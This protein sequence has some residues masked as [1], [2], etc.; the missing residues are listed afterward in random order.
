LLATSCRQAT[1]VLLAV[2]FMAGAATA[3]H[4]QSAVYHLHS[5]ASTTGSFKQ[6]KAAGPDVAQ[7]TLQTAAL[8]GAAVGEKQIAQFDTATGV[9]GTAGRIPS[10]AMVSAVVWMRKTANF[11][12]MFPRIKVRLNSSAG[13]SL[14]TATGTTALTTT[15]T[16][17]SISCTTTANVTVAASDRLYVWAGVNLTVASSGGAFRGELGLEGTLNGAADSRVDV[18]TALPAP[19]ITSPNPTAG[20]VGTVVTIS[21]NNFR[22]QQLNGV[23]RFFNNRTAT[24]TSWSNTSIVATV[25]ASAVNGNVTVTVAGVASAGTWFG[26]GTVPVITQVSPTAGLPGSAVT[27]T[28]S[29]FGATKGSSAVRF[30]GVTAATTSWSATSIGATVPAAATSGNVVVTV[31]NIPSAGTPFTVPTLTSITVLPQSL[32]VPIGGAQQLTALGHYSDSIDRNISSAVSWSSTDVDVVSVSPTGLV[33]TLAAAGSATI[34][35]SLGASSNVAE[36]TAAP[37]RFK[38]VGSLQTPRLYHAA[39]LL[40]GGKVLVTGGQDGYSNV[41]ATAEVYDSATGRFTPTGNM[42]KKRHHHTATTL[43]DGRVLIVGGTTYF[44]DEDH[45]TAEI[46]DPA[47]G[48]FAFTGSMSVPRLFHTAALL[49]DGRVLIEQGALGFPYVPSAEVYNP[50]TGT[51]SVTTPPAT[52]RRYGHTG[53]LLNNGGVLLAGGSDDNGATATTDIYD[54]VADTYASNPPL[55]LQRRGHSA[56]GLVD[57]RVVLVGGYDPC[58]TACTAEVFDPGTASF[59]PTQPLSV[60]RGSHTATLLP[61][62]NVLIAGGSGDSGPTPT[63]ELFDPATLTFIAAGAMATT[64]YVHTATALPDGSVLLVGGYGDLSKLSAELYLPAPVPP[65]SLRITPSSATLQMGESRTFRVVDHLGHART[66]VEW[67]SSDPLIASVEEATGL[68]AGLATGSVTLTATIGAATTT[69]QVTI[70]AAGSL[71]AGTPRWSAAP[72]AGM[73]VKQVVAGS[74]SDNDDLPASFVVSGDTSNTQ[75]QALTATGL[76]LWEVWVPAGAS[77]FVP[78]TSGGL[79]MTLYNSCDGVNPMRL[80]NFDGATGLWAWQ[81]VGATTCGSETPRVSVRPGGAVAVSTPGNLTGFPTLMLLDGIT[82][83]ALPVPLIPSSTFTSF[84]GEQTPGV[85]RIGPTMTDRDG[86]VHVLYEK[87]TVGYPPQVL[88]T[89]IWLMSVHQDQS[90]STTQLSSTN[91]NTNLFP[92]HI[93]PDGTG[94]LVATWIDSPIVS[95]GQ[96]PAQSTFRAAHVAGASITNFDLP[97]V[98]PTDLPKQPGSALPVNPALTLGETGRAFVTHMDTLVAF[99]VNDGGLLWQYQAPSGSMT[100]VRADETNGVFAK[101]TVDGVD[102][103]LYFNPSGSYTTEAIT[104][105]GVDYFVGVGWVGATASSDAVAYAGSA[106]NVS[107]SGWSAPSQQHTEA[108]EPVI[109]FRDIRQDGSQQTKIQAILQLAQSRLEADPG[110]PSPTCSTWFNTGGAGAGFV[111]AAQYIGDFLLPD[112][113]AHAEFLEGGSPNAGEH[114]SAMVGSVNGLPNTRITFN[115]RG[116]FFQSHFSL[117]TYNPPRRQVIGARLSPDGTETGGYTG[118][119]QRAQL[120]IVLHELAHLLQ[121]GSPSVTTVPGFSTDGGNA[122]VSRANTDLLLTHCRALIER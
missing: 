10:G 106:I 64:R 98:P 121:S 54:P 99:N 51:F 67:T 60:G 122:T 47:T 58:P 79:L 9:P 22:N 34:S 13:T 28:G 88:D 55:T 75:I 117:G 6:L 100:I 105:V 81:F 120:T 8:Q 18:P 50:A 16:A 62:G 95:V 1:R 78:N 68:T 5:E 49:S 53:T 107:R 3:A 19:V 37:S 103:V 21:G 73:T 70:V 83:S 74:R 76:F 15:L 63:A 82:G 46:Y 26:V 66:D 52:V 80:V 57:G 111:T 59:A 87:R 25:P 112:H 92:G 41:T 14:C 96:P 71:P 33:T 35:A 31:N 65:L 93:I 2:G 61:D 90:F 30:N 86:V 32:T 104:G 27:I 97:L 38:R 17:Y 36:I 24:V 39:A 20:P 116:R 101:N 56:T 119:S 42:R 113:F 102:T 7:A 23:V 48:T 77:N 69:A 85:S 4:G 12:T 40:P 94:G 109:T 108:A 115:R 118:G 43:L 84:N 91:A 89:G 29:N 114:T 72:P 110:L 44:P 11:G 45:A